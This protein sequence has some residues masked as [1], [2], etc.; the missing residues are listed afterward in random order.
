MACHEVA[1][2]AWLGAMIWAYH[3]GM[4]GEM[5]G[6]HGWVSRL[7]AILGGRSCSVVPGY[8]MWALLGDMAGCNVEK[9]KRLF[10]SNLFMWDK[11]RIEPGPRINKKHFR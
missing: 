9:Q 2:V 3:D 7:I 6:R 11:R 4:A 8:Y 1:Q 10:R 5:L